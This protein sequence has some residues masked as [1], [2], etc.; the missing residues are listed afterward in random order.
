MSQGEVF[1][2]EVALDVA[3]RV[4]ARLAPAC[5]RIEVAGSVRRCRKFC[6]DVDVVVWPIYEQHGQPD[7][8]ENRIKKVF[9]ARKLSAAIGELVGSRY[10]IRPETK[11]TGFVFEGVP[12]DVYLAEPD[13]GN[14]E[15]L[16]QMRTGPAGFNIDLVARA[17]MWRLVYKPGYGVFRDDVR[18]DDGTEEGIFKALGLTWIDP[19]QRDNCR[20]PARR[21][22]E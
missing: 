9:E 6:H 17:K 5:Q 20:L 3:R 21:V 4:E 15:A 18:M 10:W 16:W 11:R 7:L 14:F 2:Y 13:G 8:F 12:V 19:A 1:R 22:G